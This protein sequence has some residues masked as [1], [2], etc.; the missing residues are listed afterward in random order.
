MTFS[1][2][3][4]QVSNFFAEFEVSQKKIFKTGTF[5]RFVWYLVRFQWVHWVSLQ[6]F[7]QEVPPGHFSVG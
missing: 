3:S 1:R 6:P 7:L 2:Q 4:M 5:G